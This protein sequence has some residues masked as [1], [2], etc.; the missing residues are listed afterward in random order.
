MVVPCKFLYGL[1]SLIIPCYGVWQKRY[2][3]ADALAQQGLDPLQH[4]HI[5]GRLG[6][7]PCFFEKIP[8]IKPVTG[9]IEIVDEVSDLVRLRPTTI[10]RIERWRS[11]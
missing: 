6:I 9:N 4:T 2:R 1:S 10:K 11:D 7:N 8:V 3:I 5:E